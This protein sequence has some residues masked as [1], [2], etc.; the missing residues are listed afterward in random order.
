LLVKRE[1]WFLLRNAKCRLRN[2]FEREMPIAKCFE[3]EVQ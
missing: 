3:V 2:V 1:E